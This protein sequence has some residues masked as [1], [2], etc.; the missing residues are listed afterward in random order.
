LRIA[1]VGAGV[2]GAY[3][4][5]IIPSEHKVDVY[6]MKEKE[7]WWTVCAWGTCEPY[8]AELV[9]KA[10]FSFQKYVL[11]RGKKMSVKVGNKEIEIKLIGLVTY[12]KHELTKD[13]LE[14]KN[15]F[16]GKKI[17][18][19]EQLK[20]YNMVIDATGFHRTLLPKI[21]NDIYIPSV[22]YQVKSE[23]L[24]YDDFVIKPY[25]GLSGY[26]WYFPLGDNMAHVGAG[27]YYGKYRGELEEFIKKYR[28][29]VIRKIGRPVRVSPP[30]EC[31][32]FYDDS[33]VGV[34]ESIG[35]VYPLLGEGIIPSMQCAEIFVRNINNMKSYEKEVLRHYEI[36][37]KVYRFIKAKL[38][39]QFNIVKMF[40]TLLSVFMYMKRNERRYGL[41]VK[42]SDFFKIVTKL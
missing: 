18:N 7:K 33:V 4:A 31:L 27:D 11:H 14:G 29:E 19:K 21:K 8:I 3:L 25:S 35:T 13:M 41:E 24:P 20:G 38:F 16:W 17:E 39:R 37:T 28:C 30:S 15:V 36:Y 34:G 26:W 23:S 32:P 40:P 12:D 2:A 5:N 9:K 22:E 1:I 42:L 6:E 10:G